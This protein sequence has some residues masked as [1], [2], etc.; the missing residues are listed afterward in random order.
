M[1]LSSPHLNLSSHF[2]SLELWH[3]V[4]SSMSFPIKNS[5]LQHL[6]K[7]L[8]IVFF[9]RNSSSVTQGRTLCMRRGR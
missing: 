2:D 9:S 5:S 7:P 8:T 4:H 6:L 1:G 3:T